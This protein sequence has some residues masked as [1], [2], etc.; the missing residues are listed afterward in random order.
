MKKYCGVVVLFNPDDDVRLNIDSYLESVSKLYIID[1]SKVENN[2]LLNEIR[3]KEKLE[4]IPLG[5][6]MGLAYA[7]NLGCR[8]A[9][10]DGF[11]YILTMDQDS[12]FEK[13]AVN[14]MISF[15]EK[16]AVHYS[17]VSPN[18]SSVYYDES[19][20]QDEIAYTHLK[21]DEI[22]ERNW[23]MT[24]GS[25]MCLKDYQK[26]GGFDESLFIAHIDIDIAIKFD[27][28]GGK[29]IQIGNAIIYQRFGNSK[30]KKFFW[31]TIYPSF[32]SPVRTY[33]LFRNQKYL[34]KKW[35]NYNSFIDV[36]LYKF[37]IKILL[38]EDMKFKKI[39]MGLKGLKDARLNNMGTYKE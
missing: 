37:I 5:E 18:V 6:N 9:V 7:L 25:L 20:N 31:K 29:I 36:H 10:L 34:E 3:T 24:S 8:K 22:V 4:Y 33:Y 13:F 1:N 39:K 11:D 16:S 15:I 14:K 28:F 23:V 38:Y 12:R 32:A 19:S 30:P 27:Q 35:D 2:L 17:I 26:A 21:N